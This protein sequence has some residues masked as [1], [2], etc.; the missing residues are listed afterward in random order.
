MHM[1]IYVHSSGY[2]QAYAS[3]GCTLK[4]PYVSVCNTL[5]TFIME[6]AARQ[7][8]NAASVSVGCLAARITVL[9]R[10]CSWHLNA[11]RST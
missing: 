7:A 5:V 11:G 3:D 6:C 4:L 9:G 8:N 1:Y 2:A 10:L